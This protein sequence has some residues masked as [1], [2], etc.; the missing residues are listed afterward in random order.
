MQSRPVRS[1]SMFRSF[2]WGR[3]IVLCRVGGLYRRRV[4]GIVLSRGLCLGCSV[5]WRWIRYR[6]T[7]SSLSASGE[8]VIRPTPISEDVFYPSITIKPHP[9]RSVFNARIVFIIRNHQQ[10]KRASK[11]SDWEKCTL[12]SYRQLSKVWW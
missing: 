11:N 8:A 6:G 1:I 9:P 10:G 7:L 2:K 5:C 4:Q 12:P 3:G